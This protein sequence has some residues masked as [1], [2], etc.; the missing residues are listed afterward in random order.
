MR[1]YLTVCLLSGVVTP[2]I[3]EHNNQA[4]SSG[5]RYRFEYNAGI[6][7]LSYGDYGGFTR[8]YT[9]RSDRFLRQAGS[10]HE[11]F[12]QYCTIPLAGGCHVFVD[13][14]KTNFKLAAGV[15]LC[16]GVLINFDEDNSVPQGY[17]HV[18]VDP[19]AASPDL[20]AELLP[21]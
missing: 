16:M 15:I 13:R 21:R 11:C 17:V 9:R 20:R 7:G 14:D 4:M 1:G 12:A 5:L 3:T 2:W 18:W 8:C 10:P 6:S 19:N